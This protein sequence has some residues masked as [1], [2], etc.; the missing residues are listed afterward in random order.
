MRELLKKETVFEW[1][2]KHDKEWKMLKQTLS[3][4]PV[5]TFFD[6]ARKTKISTDASKE[7]LGA[8]LLQAVGDI[9]QPVAYASRTMTDTEQRY[10]QIE[11]ETLG[12][13]YGCVKFHS[14]VYGLPAFTMET[15]HKPLISTVKKN[16]NDMSPQI[17]RLMMKL[18]R[19]DFL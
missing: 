17:Q 3:T 2:E 12:L 15:D 11:K 7:G 10:A 8:V 13:V 18:Q 5:L 19:Y 1:T 6:P 14:Y 4:E 9:W 16:L